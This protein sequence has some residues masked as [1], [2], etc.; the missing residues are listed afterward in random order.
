VYYL[1]KQTNLKKQLQREIN[2]ELESNSGSAVIMNNTE[3]MAKIFI[4]NFDQVK[5]KVLGHVCDGC[6]EDCELKRAC[7]Y[8]KELKIEKWDIQYAKMPSNIIWENQYNDTSSFLTMIRTG[9][10]NLI[11]LLICIFIATPTALLESFQKAKLV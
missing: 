7:K 3:T 6:P 5:S 11:V 2:T 1:R 8:G 4:E 10:I 9:I